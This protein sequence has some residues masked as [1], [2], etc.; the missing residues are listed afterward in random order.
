[1]GCGTPWMP[2]SSQEPFGDTAGDGHEAGPAGT[3]SHARI[4]ALFALTFLLM[5]PETLPVPVL[6][7]LIVER[8]LVSDSLATLFLVANMIGAL[9]ATP[10]VGLRVDRTGR[11]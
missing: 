3:L 8:F 5:L 10:L 1:M 7:G 9:I 4:A 6:R 11:R 2:A